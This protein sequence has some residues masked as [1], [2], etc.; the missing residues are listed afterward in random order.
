MRASWRRRFVLC[1]CLVT[2][3]PLALILILV[4]RQQRASLVH[5]M[6]R[7][8]ETIAVHLAA[9]STKSLLNYN[10]VTLEQDAE[11]TA[12]ERDVLYVIILDR[13]GRVAAYSGQHEKQGL[14][15]TD[16]VSQQAAEAMATL[17]QHVPSIQGTAEHDDIAVPVCVPDSREKWGTVRLGFSLHEM[18]QEIT[19]TRWQ[20][21]VLGVLG[22]A[23]SLV[24][25]AFLAKSGLRT[26]V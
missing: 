15:L 13:D 22:V 21:L 20:L 9:M 7:C 19:Q 25:A 12:Q 10:F 11:T 2:S 14:V 18:Q 16:A 8:G 6:E 23:V 3:L 24:M 26:P 4:E 17:I 1:S 5:H